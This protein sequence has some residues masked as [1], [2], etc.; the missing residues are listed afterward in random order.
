MRDAHETGAELC[1]DAHQDVRLRPTKSYRCCPHAAVQ[2]VQR[3]IDVCM[4][5]AGFFRIAQTHEDPER[6]LRWDVSQDGW[7]Q[8]ITGFTIAEP[9]SF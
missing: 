3:L 2:F 9:T 5:N 8:R 1:Y 4:A 7:L 6:R